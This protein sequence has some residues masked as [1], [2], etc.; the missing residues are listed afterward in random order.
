MRE[1]SELELNPVIRGSNYF[2]SDNVKFG[3]RC[4]YAYQLLYVYDGSGTA[5]VEGRYYNLEPGMLFMYGPGQRHEFRSNS[6]GFLTLGTVNFSGWIVADEKLR[7]GNTSVSEKGDEFVLYADELVRFAGL[8]ELP[9]VMMISKESGSQLGM[10]IRQI[11]REQKGSGSQLVM[12]AR[13]LEIFVLL[14]AE[15]GQNASEQN[16]KLVEFEEYIRAN[17]H[18]DLKRSDVSLHLKLSESYLTA[19]LGKELKTNF[20]DYLTR[21]RLDKAMELV[22]FSDLLVKEI[23][24]RTGFKSVSYFVRRFGDYFGSPPNQFRH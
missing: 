24:D 8:S 14:K 6:G 19:L 4:N 17:Y 20:T 11:Y 23:S 18:R 21:I 3:P 22:Q 15:F 12:K 2:S 5:E 10:L 9:F 13:M 16:S 7:M 1:I